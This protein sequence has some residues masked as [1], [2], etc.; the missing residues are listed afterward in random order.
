MNVNVI[1]KT[2]NAVL[3][4]KEIEAEVSFDGATPSRNDIRKA[5]SSKVGI[6]P[7]LMVLREISSSFGKQSVKVIAHAYSKKEQMLKTEPEYMIKRY[8]PAEQTKAE[9]PKEEKPKAEAKPKEE[10]PKAEKKE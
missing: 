3:E 10:K 8:A 9:E 4:R 6:N 5:I 2:D 1:S 7:D